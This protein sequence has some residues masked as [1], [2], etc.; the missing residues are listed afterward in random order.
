MLPRKRTVP[1]E[2]AANPFALSRAVQVSISDEI[3]EV[4]PSLAPLAALPSLPSPSPR[5]DVVAS[6]HLVRP[7]QKPVSKRPPPLP[8]A[9]LASAR[10][11]PPPPLPN[12]LPRSV[13]VPPKLAEAERA[14]KRDV[15]RV[16]RPEGRPA[17]HDSESSDAVAP[18]ALTARS[19]SARTS[20]TF[21]MALL[22]LGV[23]GGVVSAIVVGGDSE[24]VAQAG[25]KDGHYTNLL[26]PVPVATSSMTAAATASTQTTIAPVQKKAAA[27]ERAEAPAPERAEPAALKVVAVKPSAPP[28]AAAVP[29]T[30]KAEPKS[31]AKE[32]RASEPPAK[33]QVDFELPKVSPRPERV[34]AAPKRAESK[35]VA[36]PAP[37]AEKV[38]AAEKIEKPAEEEVRR[39][40][41][42]SDDLSSAAAANAQA[43]A[44]LEGSL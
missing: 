8:Y 2:P 26:D 20:V 18:M 31:E 16:K 19:P 34:A 30:L 42:M 32:A 9:A 37:P 29:T 10:R 1:A 36:R 15:G 17:A 38:A 22:A 39:K 44:Q 3:T 40:P 33:R 4:K 7:P 14:F 24:A 13:F 12:Q 43:K 28:P 6:S 35:P 27:V 5:T 23:F 21:A 25:T 41:V 11:A